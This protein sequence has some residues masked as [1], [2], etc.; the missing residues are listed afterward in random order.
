LFGSSPPRAYRI[1]VARSTA[2]ISIFSLPTYHPFP[3]GR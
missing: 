3:F 2:T 1:A